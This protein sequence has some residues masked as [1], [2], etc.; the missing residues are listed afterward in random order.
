MEAVAAAIASPM[1]D[2]QYG[3]NGVQ[4]STPALLEGI[5]EASARTGRRVHMHLL[6][7]RYQREWADRHFPGGIARHLKE[8]GL[9]SPRLTL[10][11]CT[12]ASPE[13]L[14]LIAESGATISVNTSSN[15]ACAR[16]SRR[17]RR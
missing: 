17:W 4:W 13:D 2:V 9:L 5:A 14:E 8:I 15:L 16:A 10:A 1:V 11:H 3:P 12:W 7:T 6:E